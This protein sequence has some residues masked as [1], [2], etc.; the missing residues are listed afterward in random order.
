MKPVFDLKSLPYTWI[1][2]LMNQGMESVDRGK[3][4]LTYS[5][6]DWNL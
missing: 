2:T 6:D 1:F 5:P 4:G 3:E